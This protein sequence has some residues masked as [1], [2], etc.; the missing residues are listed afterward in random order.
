VFL[1]DAD[2]RNANLFKTNLQQSILFRTDLR[3]AT[4]ADAILIGADLNY[5]RL[6]GTNLQFA[7]LHRADL[8]T[9]IG[10]SWAQISKAFITDETLLPPELE[11]R[12]KAEKAK[13]A[14]ATNP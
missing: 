3:K 10:L 7:L 2:L 14:A 1:L 11:E 6:N 4:L 5:A 13:K 12:R 9:S 8:R